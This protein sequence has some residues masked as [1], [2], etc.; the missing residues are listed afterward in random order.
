MKNINTSIFDFAEL[1]NSDDEYIYV[2]KTRQLYEL[3]KKGKDKIYYLPRPRRFGK[4]LMIS[5]PKYLFL[6]RR[7][8][9]KGL[10]ID[11][12]PWDW[13]KEV[14]PVLHLDMA[15]VASKTADELERSLK[16][17]MEVAAKE[18]GMEVDREKS[19]KEILF[20]LL[21]YLP[22]IAPKAAGGKYVVLID[23]YDAPISGL[24]DTPEGRVELPMVRKTLHDF[25]VQ[26]KSECGN[27]RFLMVTGVSKFAKTSIFSAFNNPCDLTLDVRAAD[28]LGYTHGEV[29]KYFHE[30]I[31]AFADS[32]GIS[33]EKMFARLLDWYDSYQFSPDRLVKVVNPVSLG[34]ALTNKKIANYW[35]ATA[36]ST[37]IFDALKAGNKAPLDFA[38]RF[39]LKRLDAADALD[40]PTVALL[41]QGGYL[42]IDKPVNDST[43]WLKIPNREVSDSLYDGYVGQ[44]LGKDFEID[45]LENDAD[46]TAERIATDP[47]GGEMKRLLVSA[48]AR[49]PHDW[50]C[51]NEKEAKRYFIAFM[52]FARAEVVGEEQHSLGRP[53]AV[54]KTEKAIY[55]FEFKYDQ[56]AQAAIDQ[57]RERDYAAAFT[58]DARQVVYVGVNYDSSVRTVSD[59]KCEDAILVQRESKSISRKSKSK[60]TKAKSRK[61]KR[62]A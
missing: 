14:Y 41:Y 32:E 16:T 36:D 48:Y 38:A 58:V 28:L 42:T 6:G 50:V 31:Q 52:V 57:C 4:S 1:R 34:K 13:D 22:T 15:H 62:N 30:H 9:F 47:T 54:L 10:W 12:S 18:F 39:K 59:V 33:Y 19:A 46:E 25:Y 2:D 8:L 35:E 20:L 24:L 53:D 40:A 11:S 29:E 56:S 61:V 5:T 23:E 60:T 26:A 45:E 3:L 49:L 37:L 17:L 55:I 7:D 21:R 27:M 43:V 51:K 44:L